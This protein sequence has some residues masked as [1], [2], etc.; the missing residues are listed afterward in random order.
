MID[1]AAIFVS[2]PSLQDRN[3]L[4]CIDDLDQFR[5]K[6]TVT[7][8]ALV[9]WYMDWVKL[10]H[11]WAIMLTERRLP[12]LRTME[13]RHDPRLLEA[14]A[15]LIASVDLH[16]LVV[17]CKISPA[18]RQATRVKGAKTAVFAR[19][20]SRMQALVPGDSR[21]SMTV[22]DNDSI[23]MEFY[24]LVKAA[25]RKTG[26]MLKDDIA[27]ICFG[28]DTRYAPLQAADLLAFCGRRKMERGADPVYERLTQRPQVQHVFE[29]LSL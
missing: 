19:A 27:S 15:A 25:R 23:A 6:R 29:T 11:Q 14:F 18:R 1:V 2:L 5:G 16:S 26:L 10:A 3:W 4:A 24:A 22:D 28:N 20:M 9:G 7:F 21:L 13:H 8:C 12:Y 17:G